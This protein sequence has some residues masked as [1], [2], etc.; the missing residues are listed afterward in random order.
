MRDE[1]TKVRAM[2]TETLY[3]DKPAWLAAG[4]GLVLLAGLNNAQAQEKNDKK[5]KQAKPTTRS[6]QQQHPVRQ[7]LSQ[8]QRVH[9]PRQDQPRQNQN[10]T[11]QHPQAERR[12]EL[13]PQGDQHQNAKVPEPNPSQVVKNPP[14]QNSQTGTQTGAAPERK[15]LPVMKP[16]QLTEERKAGGVTERKDPSGRLVERVEVDPKTGHERIQRL[17]PT[18]KV[19][20]ETRKTT[21]GTMRKTNYDQ[22][23]MLKKEELVYTDGS[24]R[25][26]NHRTGRDGYYRSRET[27]NYG[28]NRQAVSRTVERTVTINTIRNKAAV[29][30]HYDR[31]RYG[32]VY[33]PIYL[34]RPR[35]F[36]TWCDPYWYNP[37][38]HWIHRPFRYSWGW[39]RHHWYHRYHGAYWT[40]YT[41]Y[42]TPS[43]W[44]TD[45]V[46]AAYVADHHAANPS[47][48]EPADQENRAGRNP[49]ATPIDD[50]TKETLR[51]QIEQ[52]IAEQKELAEQS[53]KIGKP[54][55][56]DLSKA[57][58]DPNHIYPV[59]KAISV[60]AAKDN[61]PAGILSEGDLLKVE[62]GQEDILKGADENT[63]VLMRVMTSK[64]EE[65]EVP[66]G[67]VI[68]VFVKDLQEFDSEFR[69]KLDEALV[70]A[71]SNKD[72]FKGG[73]IAPTEK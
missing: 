64:G 53:E 34:V 66:A 32:F 54:I 18:G 44:M 68:K 24:R 27:I 72:A 48:A 46:V 36:V 4:L 59:S 17:S 12:R 7:Q 1:I 6:N 14:S 10:G 11:A 43:Y 71:E 49:K 52:T 20:S 15:S 9:G 23:G 16:V 25:V 2:K 63:E 37:V 51:K 61:A 45:Y 57:L 50:A 26:T 19:E 69:A 8:D 39:E 42:P 35:V 62:P 30:C 13:K 38:G 73:L 33:R 21:D 28:V 58:M 65:N 22:Q 29:K 31:G 55:L 60:V 47:A 67:T 70:A 41:V 3:R 56:P 5:E 40:T